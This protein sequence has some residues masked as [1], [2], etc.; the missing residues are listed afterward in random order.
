MFNVYCVVT[1]CPVTEDFYCD[2]PTGISNDM[3]LVPSSNFKVMIDGDLTTFPPHTAFYYPARTPF[4]Y[5][6]TEGEY[7][8]YFIHFSS[9]NNAYKE[10]HLPIGQPIY[11]TEPSDIYSLM[12][13]IAR[14]NIL[15]GRN[16]SEILDNLMKN[17]FLKIGENIEN[18]SPEPH[19]NELYKI[20]SRIY[21][22]PEKEWSL[23]LIASDLHMSINNIHRLYKKFF[24]TSFINDVIESRLR[25]AKNY[26]SHTNYTVATIAEY[27]GYNNVEHFS[28]QF[29]QYTGITPKRYRDQEA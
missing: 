26:L 27:C 23:D 22:H 15:T 20:R 6:R 7:I 5:T 4:C 21:L 19:Y 29:K 8:D 13:M 9:D 14:E 18:N 1:D 28:R 2:F 3:I 25:K 24:G 10:F 12:K 16:R 17:L 11:I